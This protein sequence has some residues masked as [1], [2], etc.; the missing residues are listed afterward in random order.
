MVYQIAI[1][2]AYH[3][4]TW[5]TRL[6][7]DA[8][9]FK[10]RLQTAKYRGIHGDAR[11]N[12]RYYYRRKRLASLGFDRGAASPAACASTLPQFRPPYNNPRGA[13][14]EPENLSSPHCAPSM[15]CRQRPTKSTMP[16]ML[17]P[18][19][20]QVSKC[21]SVQVSKC[22]SVQVFKCASVQVSKRPSVPVVQVFKCSSVQVCKC[23]SVQASKCPSV[24]VFKCSSVQVFHCQSVGIWYPI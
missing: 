13:S 22:S 6:H 17:H 9:F 21:S 5:Y 12:G 8:L 18:S 4:T 24:R 20:V 15:F 1:W 10:S 16:T 23:P 7:I 11:S 14:K 19:S 3:I 2:M